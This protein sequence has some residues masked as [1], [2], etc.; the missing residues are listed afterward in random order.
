MDFRRIAVGV[1]LIMSASNMAPAQTKKG[2]PPAAHH[3]GKPPAKGG[4]PGAGTPETTAA[5][6]PSGEDKDN[7]YG[8]APASEAAPPPNATSPTETAPAGGS[9]D[10]KLDEPPPPR[11]E[12]AAGPGTS[13]LTPAA[14]EFPPSAP[15]A[16]P[17][18]L[19]KL[20]ADIAT[21]RGRVA[22]LTTSLFSSKLRVSLRTSGDDARIQSIVVTLDEGVVFRAAAGFVA[23]DEK[24][25]Y[26]HAAAPGSHVV[27]IE[28]ERQDA[29]GAQFRTW[30]VSRFAIQIPERKT[31]E[32]SVRVDD[33]SDMA[34]DFPDDKDGEYELG[35]RLRA[36]VPD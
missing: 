25:V 19:D 6:A 31:L 13:P 28:V 1:A 17:E 5:P 18:A 23:E 4:K 2:A 16:S 34:D 35:I 12:K 32:A 22:A 11:T 26:E 24:V 8:D 36:K 14:N 3:K 20:M 9:G 21:L 33:D 10:A 30:Q 15:K 7:P 29:R 27:G